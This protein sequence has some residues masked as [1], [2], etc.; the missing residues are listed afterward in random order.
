MPFG[1]GSYVASWPVR[2]AAEGQGKRPLAASR[3]PSASAAM[4][5]FDKMEEQVILMRQL[6]SAYNEATNEAADLAQRLQQAQ[7]ENDRLQQEVASLMQANTDCCNQVGNCKAVLVKLARVLWSVL[8]CVTALA[9]CNMYSCIMFPDTQRFLHVSCRK[10]FLHVSCTACI[11]YHV[12]LYHV[13][14]PQ[15]FLL[16]E[17]QS[18]PR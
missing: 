3:G 5:A 6:K 16:V 12:Q 9:S 17:Y 1:A 4:A 15:R 7:L 2:A 18:S 13:R 14:L 11:M 10:R 8:D